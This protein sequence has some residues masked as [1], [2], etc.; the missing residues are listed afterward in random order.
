MLPLKRANNWD[1]APVG[2]AVIVRSE[3]GS[4]R[5]LDPTQIKW[6]DADGNYA[7]L[8]LES[9]VLPCH[10][11]IGS[12]AERLDSSRFLRIHRSTIVNITKIGEVRMNGQGQYLVVLTDGQRRTVSRTYRKTIRRLV[13]GHISET[14]APDFR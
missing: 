2:D 5:F 4:F 9:E 6:I 11:S 8:N 1:Q 14:E 13:H 3:A 10:E 7:R 12:L